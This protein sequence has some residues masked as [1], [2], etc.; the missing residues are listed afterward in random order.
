[1]PNIIMTKLP[2]MVFR[3]LE[4]KT[5]LQD[6]EEYFKGRIPSDL[7]E[8]LVEIQKTLDVAYTRGYLE[9][10]EAMASLEADSTDGG[11]YKQQRG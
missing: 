10:M 7:R 11:E 2:D 4:G 6:A 9:G 1:M 8:H 3:S 5:V